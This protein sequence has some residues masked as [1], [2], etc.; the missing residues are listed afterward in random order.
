MLIVLLDGR[1]IESLSGSHSVPGG[2]LV[3]LNQG[4]LVVS[5]LVYRDGV[6]D[7]GIGSQDIEIGSRIV[8]VLLSMIANMYAGLRNL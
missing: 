1:M 5:S 2:L 4:P 6:I 7:K 3:S 8:S